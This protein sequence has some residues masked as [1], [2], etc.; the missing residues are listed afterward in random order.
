MSSTSWSTSRLPRR[1]SLMSAPEG[2]AGGCRCVLWSQA[3]CQ[4]AYARGRSA[5]NKPKAGTVPPYDGI[6]RHHN[7]CLFPGRPEAIKAIKEDPEQFIQHRKFRA[8]ALSLEHCQLLTQSQIFNQ[9][10]LARVK[11]PN[12]DASPKLQRTEHALNSQPSKNPN[13]MPIARRVRRKRQQLRSTDFIAS[14]ATHLDL[15]R[16]PAGRDLLSRPAHPHRARQSRSLCVGR[17]APQH[18][19]TADVLYH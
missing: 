14:P 7:Q 13:R 18:H 4:Q 15:R 19:G 17:V 8:A 2:L 10:N 9:Q 16:L 1:L 11:Q 12:E 3:F 5:G 6:G